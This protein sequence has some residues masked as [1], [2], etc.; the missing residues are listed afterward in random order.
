M[1][2][3]ITGATGQLG[4]IVIEKLLLQT[5]A[6]NIVALVRNP[7]NATHLTAQNIEVREFDYDRPETL[8]PALSG[9]DKLLLISANEVGRRTP[10][11]KAV[12]D[13]AKVVG[14]P[15]LAYTSLLRAD[16]SPLGLA[17]EHRETEKLIQDSGLRYTFLRNN[18]Y[19][20]NYLAGVAHTIEIGTLFG[21]AQD[22]RI[23]SASRIDY[24]EAAARVL[25]STVH[26]NQTYELAGSQSFSLSELA[27]LIGQAASKTI[28]YQN[29]SAE[30]YTQGLIQASLPAGLVEVIVDADIQTIQGAMYSDSQ[31]LEQLIGRKTTNIQDAIKAAL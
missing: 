14:V 7:A 18:W 13:A 31:D 8:V 30:E 17:Q 6:N 19:S 21:A 25:T 15:Y 2:I 4:S 23:S 12:I 3:A 16:T 1:K 27:T 29:L 9:I 24:A 22:G 28:N 20:E 26:D 5:E 10:Q 11:H